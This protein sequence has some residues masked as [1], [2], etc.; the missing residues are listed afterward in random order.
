[1]SAKR[2]AAINK[3][4]LKC[5]Y[6]CGHSTVLF[7]NASS[8]LFYLPFFPIV[9]PLTTFFLF[10]FFSAADAPSLQTN[11]HTAEHLLSH[12]H[13]PGADNEAAGGQHCRHSPDEVNVCVRWCG[14]MRGNGRKEEFMHA[15]MFADV[16]RLQPNSNLCLFTRLTF[17]L[18]FVTTNQHHKPNQH[19]KRINNRTFKS[20]SQSTTHNHTGKPS[21]PR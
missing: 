14:R 12:Q 4:S 17:T 13:C 20:Q 1:M 7:P 15:A 5:R 2:K 16:C 3:Q 9:R 8:L 6:L 10:F 19:H 21:A 18:L 11:T